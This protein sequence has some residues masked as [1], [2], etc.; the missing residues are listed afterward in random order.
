MGVGGGVGWLKMPSKNTCE[1][2]HFILKLPAI[3]MQ[4]CK[5]TRNELL[6]TYFSRI[7]ARFQVIIYCAFT[8][9]HFMEGHFAFQWRGVVFQMEGGASFLSG[10][11]APWGGIAFDV[12]GGGVQKKLNGGG[13]GGGGAPPHAPHYGKPY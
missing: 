12:E 1:E 4:A 2:V 3:S 5:F 13:G 10:V 6:R 9:N 8:R 7:L 11:C